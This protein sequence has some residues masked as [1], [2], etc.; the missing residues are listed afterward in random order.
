MNP[1]QKPRYWACDQEII[2]R[3]RSRLERDRFCAA[4]KGEALSARNP[5]IRTA[6]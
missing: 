3:F 6:R 1:S 5:R 2:Y 4:G